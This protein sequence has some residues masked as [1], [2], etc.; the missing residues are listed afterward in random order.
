MNLQNRSEYQ[1]LVKKIVPLQKIPWK[2]KKHRLWNFPIVKIHKL[3]G[4]VIYTK[5]FTNLC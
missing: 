2:S 4:E 1:P 3:Y 5:I